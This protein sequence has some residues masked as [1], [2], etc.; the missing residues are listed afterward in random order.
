MAGHVIN[1]HQGRVQN[2]QDETEIDIELLRKYITYAKVSCAPRLTEE[3]G[4]ILKSY[5]IKDREEAEVRERDTRGGHGKIP[6]TVR[7]LEAI[8]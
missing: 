2:E 4:A 3:A 8:I 6:I 1:L 5:Y 7:Q